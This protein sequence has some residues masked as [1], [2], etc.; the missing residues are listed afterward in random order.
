MW[1]LLEVGEV[2]QRDDEYILNANPWEPI[3]SIIGIPFK[4]GD[5]P[6]RRKISDNSEVQ[7]PTAN[8]DYTAVLKKELN[9]WINSAP[10]VVAEKDIHQFAA[11][12][13]AVINKRHCT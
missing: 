5:N 9:Q 7:K 8:I 11:H 6:V 10:S 3:G 13:N 4:D 2:R 12:L 1:R